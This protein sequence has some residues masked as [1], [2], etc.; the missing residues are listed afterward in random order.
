MTIMFGK[1]PQQWTDFDNSEK[2]TIWSIKD[3]IHFLYKSV[4]H[5]AGFPCFL[6]PGVDVWLGELPETILIFISSL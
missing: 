6:L 4:S 1:R 2:E 5:R 3:Q